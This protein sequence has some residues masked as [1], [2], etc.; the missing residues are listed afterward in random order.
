MSSGFSSPAA[1]LAA[2]RWAARTIDLLHEVLQRLRRDGEVKPGEGFAEVDVGQLVD[3]EGEV[4]EV[5][6]AAQV[7]AAAAEVES[8]VQ[9]EIEGSGVELERILQCIG[10]DGEEACEVE[11]ADALGFAEALAGE[12]VG[13]RVSHLLLHDRSISRF[14]RLVRKLVTTP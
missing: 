12:D 4:G 14:V 8:P 7:E 2:R 6:Q 9:V 1:A 5:Q 3:V 10:V 11:V 13:G